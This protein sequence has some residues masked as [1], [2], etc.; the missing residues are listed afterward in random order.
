MLK[1]KILN[2]EIQIYES[3]GEY[4]VYGKTFDAKDELKDAGAVF[5]AQ[6]K[7]LII[8]KENFEKLDDEIKQKIYVTGEIQKQ[9]SLSKI[10]N[11]IADGK[12]E[13]SGVGSDQLVIKGKFK[14]LYTDLINC[15]FQEERKY[16]I[17][18]EKFNENFGDKLNEVSKENE[19]EF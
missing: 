16:T 10:A 6:R 13:I 4:L 3:R 8:S 11:L 9:K 5:D 19:M 18:E 12:L 7:K 14:G 15:E 17:S 2:E 1:D